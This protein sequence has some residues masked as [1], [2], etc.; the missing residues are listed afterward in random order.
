MTLWFAGV[1]RLLTVSLTVLCT[2]LGESSTDSSS[3]PQFSKAYIDVDWGQIHLLQAAPD[4]ITQPP[5]VCFPLIPFQ[6]I[7]I[8]N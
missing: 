4:L 8:A 1:A 6:A 7:T 3:Q 2:P 5:L